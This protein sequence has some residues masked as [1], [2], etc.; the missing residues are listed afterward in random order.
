MAAGLHLQDLISVLYF[1]DV[2]QR[3]AHPHSWVLS[4]PS[5]PAGALDVLYGTYVLP[6]FYA[7][8]GHPRPTDAGG[9]LQWDDQFRSSGAAVSVTS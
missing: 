8:G 9:R 7:C 4:A 6:Y 3:H 2:G 1:V 5:F